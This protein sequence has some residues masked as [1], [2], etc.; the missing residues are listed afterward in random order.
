MDKEMHEIHDEVFKLLM[1]YHKKDENFLFTMRQINRGGKLDKGYWFLGNDD[2]LAVSF[3]KGVDWLSKTPRI[4]F[5]IYKDGKSSIELRN[6]DVYSHTE[7]FPDNLIKELGG[8]ENTSSITIPFRKNNHL[9]SLQEF[10]QKEKIL[11]D[12]FVKDK[13]LNSA[14]EWHNPMEF[15]QKRDFDKQLERIQEYRKR[16]KKKKEESSFLK[17]IQIQNFG[18]IKNI[19]I[20]GIELE[21][22]WIFLTGENGA[23]KTSLLKAIAVGLCQNS[24]EG[25]VIAG[26]E[27]FGNY[28]IE[29]QLHEWNG[30]S[31]LHRITPNQQIKGKKCLAHSFAA[32]GPVRLLTEGSLDSN[33]FQKNLD[34]IVDKLTYGLFHPIGILRDLSRNYILN[35]SPRYHELATDDLITHLEY[36]IPNIAKIEGKDLKNLL[37]YE[38]SK[39]GKIKQGVSFEKLPSGTRS[40]VSLILDLLIRLQNQQSNV[41]DPSNYNGIVLIDEIDIHLHPK[42]QIWLIEQ[43][44]ETFPKVQFI[45]S[46][47]RSSGDISK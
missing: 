31:D 30:D 9:K 25:E 7:L 33:L 37:F 41:S 43:L 47:H 28:E 42:L 4:S 14:S 6:K 11:I 27:E 26:K 21:N 46:T 22:R 16:K 15:I 18:P 35:I 3:W 23:G 19:Q 8:K 38:Q 29:L 34:S 40:L 39:S 24:D 5:R 10:I 17:N 13:D 44:K 1:K 20:K 2:Y 32:Y 12:E 36:I 45:V